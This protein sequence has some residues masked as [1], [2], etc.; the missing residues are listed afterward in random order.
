[1][2][3]WVRSEKLYDQ[4]KNIYFE[5]WTH[6]PGYQES[7][8]VS[9]LRDEDVSEMSADQLIRRIFRQADHLVGSKLNIKMH[10]R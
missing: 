3:V 8:F 10:R 7:V 9:P 4:E 6:K 1:M 2:T 5:V